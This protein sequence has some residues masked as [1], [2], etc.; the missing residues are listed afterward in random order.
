MV[1]RMDVGAVAED[2][3][4][5]QDCRG[6][7]RKRV[8]LVHGDDALD[9]IIAC[10]E[11]LLY[12]EQDLEIEETAS[13]AKRHVSQPS[14]AAARQGTTRV[15]HDQISEALAY[16]WARQSK[17]CAARVGALAQLPQ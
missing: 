13:R 12:G 5:L 11:T 2:G 3:C 6:T 10:A 15:L 7:A 9:A 4:E 8:L 14:S 17:R 16:E 1:E